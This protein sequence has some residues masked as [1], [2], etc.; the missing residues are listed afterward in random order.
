M[1]K[2]YKNDIDWDVYDSYA[3]VAEIACNPPR[4]CEQC[5]VELRYASYYDSLDRFTLKALCPLCKRSWAVSVKEENYEKN[6]LKR[7][8]KLVKERD[9]HKCRM[10][11]E[12]C[13]G[14]LHAHHIIPKHLDPTKKYDVANGIC[15]CEAHHKMIHH[16]M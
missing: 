3:E 1:H 6:Q 11:D 14:T 7:W 12:H 8:E 2:C 10:A 4:F 15:L 13:N 5:G 16:Y 9:H